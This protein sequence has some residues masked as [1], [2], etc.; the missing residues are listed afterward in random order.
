M[1]Y[2]RHAIIVGSLLNDKD[3]KTAICFGQAR[4]HYTTGET[5]WIEVSVGEDTDVSAWLDK[6]LLR[7]FSR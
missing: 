1:D 3:G 5:T 4:G 7:S 6:Y 2:L